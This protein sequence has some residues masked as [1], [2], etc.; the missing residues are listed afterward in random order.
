MLT[1]GCEGLVT[2]RNDSAFWPKDFAADD[3]VEG[4]G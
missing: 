2:L 3:S 1:L 4:N